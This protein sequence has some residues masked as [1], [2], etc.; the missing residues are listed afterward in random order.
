[1]RE[2]PTMTAAVLT[3]F[4]GP[5][6]LVVRRDIP[7]PLPGRGQVR[8]RVSA[9][10]L[11]NT[12]VWTREGAYGTAE[13]PDARAGWLGPIAFPRIQGG[14][15]VGVIDAVG[16]EVAPQFVGRRVLVDPARYAHEG[17]DAPI[18]AVLGS[19]FDGGFADYTV[20]D[21][22]RVHDVTES[23]L[24]DEQLACLPIAAGTAMG[25]LER[26]RIMPGE[27]VVV[28]GASGGVG[29]AA[30]GLAAARGALVT[31]VTGRTK[32]ALVEQAGATRTIDR[33]GS[34][35]DV[36]AVVRAVHPGG[37]D[38][39]V[40]VVGGDQLGQLIDVLVPGGRAVVAGAVAGPVAAIDLR[41]LY[42]HNR[43]LIGSTMHTAEHFTKL[44]EHARAGEIIP[45]VAARHELSAIHDAQ[46]QFLRRDHVGK[47][48]VLPDGASQV[49]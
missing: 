31:A 47:I 16:P 12:D 5:E 14:D 10:G 24:T 44:V 23:P 3:G 39:V 38:A 25:M 4:G 2:Q 9:A 21:A 17:P 41:R 1:M 32:A 7:I 42:L 46:A 48:V 45:R 18:V 6:V 34:V 13:D 28:T 20:V 27:T 11:N 40:D 19:E 30:V 43:R 22:V 26:A 29:L 33:S 8:V 37:V 15:V 35:Q 49:C 36:V